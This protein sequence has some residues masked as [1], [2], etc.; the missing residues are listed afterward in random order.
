[1]YTIE[2][3][4]TPVSF[5]GSQRGRRR[6]EEAVRSAASA[7]GKLMTG[8]VAVEIEWLLHKRKRWES[9]H[10]LGTPDVDN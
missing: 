1:M 6:L 5:Q 10:T 2:L 8:E 9:P 4:L 3:P 7:P